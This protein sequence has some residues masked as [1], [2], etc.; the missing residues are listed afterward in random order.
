M[1]CGNMAPGS[2]GISPTL[3]CRFPF[4]NC[5]V[6]QEVDSAF[7]VQQAPKCNNT[8]TFTDSLKGTQRPLGVH[9]I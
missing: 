6:W 8:L 4:L 7:T 9:G 3:I 5:I 1:N 2:G